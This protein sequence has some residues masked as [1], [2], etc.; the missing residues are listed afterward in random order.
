MASEK[1]DH[2]L[3]PG[4]PL[5]NLDAIS[6]KQILFNF[7]VPGQAEQFL[8][9][10][11]SQAFIRDLATAFIPL[12]LSVHLSQHFQKRQLHEAETHTQYFFCIPQ[13]NLCIL[14]CYCDCLPCFQ[15]LLP[16]NVITPTHEQTQQLSIEE[17][18][19]LS[20]V[21]ITIIK[22]LFDTQHSQYS[23]QKMLAKTVQELTTRMSEHNLFTNL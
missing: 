5:I 20:I 12:D 3:S 10:G 19:D 7:I 8:L 22:C 21:I 6:R 23:M 17:T 1:S 14:N 11:H 16:C 18:Q 13:T 2:H 15:G 9:T 4:A